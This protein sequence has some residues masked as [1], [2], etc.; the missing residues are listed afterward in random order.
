[1]TRKPGVQGGESC[2]WGIKEAAI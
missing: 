2:Q 1:M